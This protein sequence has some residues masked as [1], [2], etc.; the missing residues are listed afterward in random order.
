WGASLTED[1]VVLGGIWFAFQHPFA[2][3]AALAV[4]ILLMIWLLPKLWRG[5]KA[6]FRVLRRASGDT[7]T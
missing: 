5:I 3:L 7:P 2:F 1:V 4:F 6:V